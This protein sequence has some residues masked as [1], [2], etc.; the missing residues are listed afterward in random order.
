M[1]TKNKLQTGREALEAVEK[2]GKKE[3]IFLQGWIHDRAKRGLSR[4]KTSGSATN[5]RMVAN[6]FAVTIAPNPSI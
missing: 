1:K 2:V 6:L 4:C 3:H 5:A